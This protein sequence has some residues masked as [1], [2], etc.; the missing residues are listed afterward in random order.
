MVH[1]VTKDQLA[2]VDVTDIIWCS[3]YYHTSKLLWQP[4]L[5][6]TYVFI[7]YTLRKIAPVVYE[8]K[9]FLTEINTFSKHTTFC[10]IL[11]KISQNDLHQKCYIKNM[12]TPECIQT[13]LICIQVQNIF[14]LSHQISFVSI[15][16]YWILCLCTYKYYWKIFLNTWIIRSKYI[17]KLYFPQF[18]WTAWESD[19]N[20][21][22]TTNAAPIA[23]VDYLLD[24]W[25]KYISNVFFIVFKF[26]EINNNLKV[27]N[28]LLTENITVRKRC[29]IS[30][31]G[32]S[33][34]NIHYCW[35]SVLNA[36]IIFGWFEDINTL[37]SIFPNISS[38]FV[39]LV[40]TALL[41][42]GCVA[43]RGRVALSY[44]VCDDIFKFFLPSL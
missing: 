33:T 8:I 22:Q 7:T 14:G 36:V 35:P 3:W 2:P 26:N 17:T 44:G 12:N 20:T 32:L 4:S 42:L 11:F 24:V 43:H 25:L 19:N 18:K 39:N 28:V 15:Y 1:C 38:D 34:T 16:V 5:V 10:L 27:W 29:D 30:Y 13:I 40:K 6:R 31:I 41:K 23:I 9:Y 21:Y 37:L